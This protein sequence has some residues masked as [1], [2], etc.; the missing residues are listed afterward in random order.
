[1]RFNEV[2]GFFIDKPIAFISGAVEEGVLRPLRNALQIDKIRHGLAAGIAL[3]GL[4]GC[5]FLATALAKKIWLDL[6][7]SLEVRHRDENEPE[8]VQELPSDLKDQQIVVNS[9]ACT[10]CGEDREG[11]QTNCREIVNLPCMCCYQCNDCWHR[12][13]DRRRCRGKN[14]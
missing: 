12:E 2:Q 10:T 4:A 8:I 6:C 14:G 3:I 1:M 9:F 11:G 13:K 7:E 5:A